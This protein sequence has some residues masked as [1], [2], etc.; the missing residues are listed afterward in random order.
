MKAKANA[1]LLCFF[2][3]LL[4]LGLAGCAAGIT[5]LGTG[6]SETTAAITKKSEDEKELDETVFPK[7]KIVDVKITIDADDFQNMMDNA[8]A[9]EYKKHP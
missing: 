4:I 7:D 8:S 6:D 2:S 3:I 5:S 1:F 9:E